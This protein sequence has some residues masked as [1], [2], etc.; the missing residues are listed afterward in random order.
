MTTP[1]VLATIFLLH[2]VVPPALQPP[3][4]SGTWTSRPAEDVEVIRLTP[5]TGAARGWRPFIEALTRK[6]LYEIAVTQEADQVVIAFPG[7][8]TNMLTVPGFAMAAAPSDHVVDRGEW[9]TNSRTMAEWTGA[10]L[11][12]TATTYT[13]WWRSA[14]PAD[15]QPRPTDFHMRFVLSQG[16]VPDELVLHATLTDEKGEVEYRQRFRRAP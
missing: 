3:N 4:W 7:G 15:V 1:L 13:G 11:E 2:I 5:G 10:T 9:W 12:L 14:A 6:P 16:E 8:E